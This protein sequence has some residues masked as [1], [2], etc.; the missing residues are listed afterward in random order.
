[1]KH[2]ER[3]AELIRELLT[4]WQLEFD[5]MSV[6]SEGNNDRC[7]CPQNLI[8]D[9]EFD[10]FSRF[11]LCALLPLL[12]LVNS[13]EKTF[14]EEGMQAYKSLKGYTRCLQHHYHRLYFVS[15]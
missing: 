11:Y 15:F 4:N 2:S 10:V 9:K 8:L 7:G 13:K 3:K 6:A 5:L 1:M 14:D 12:I